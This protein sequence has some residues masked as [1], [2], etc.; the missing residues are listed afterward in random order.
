M[1]NKIK[2]IMRDYDGVV[3]DEFRADIKKELSDVLW[4]IA[5]LA[6]ELDLDEVAEANIKKLY[7]RKERGTLHGSGDDR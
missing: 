7:S 4:Y 1:L 2:K 5:A 6:S 3:T